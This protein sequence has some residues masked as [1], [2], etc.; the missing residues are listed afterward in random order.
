MLEDNLFTTTICYDSAIA[1]VSMRFLKNGSSKSS[2]WLPKL[3]FLMHFLAMSHGGQ[4]TWTYGCNVQVLCQY[5]NYRNHV[6]QP[7]KV[8]DLTF[9]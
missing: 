8:K 1:I 4:V 6:H 3:L 2:G 7:I 9:P 5:D